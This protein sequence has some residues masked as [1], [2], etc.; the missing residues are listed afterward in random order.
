[1]D[2]DVFMNEVVELVVVIPTSPRSSKT[3]SECKSYHYFRIAC[4]SWPDYPGQTWNGK[5]GGQII[6]PKME[7]S[8]QIICPKSG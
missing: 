3:E 6:Q 8:S 4:S 2:Y 5:S 1:L 7:I